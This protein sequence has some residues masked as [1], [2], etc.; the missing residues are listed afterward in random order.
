MSPE[1]GLPDVVVEIDLAGL[2]DAGY[3]I[4][5]V[6]RVSNVVEGA[7]GRV[8]SMAGG[9]YELYFPYPIAPE[10]IKVVTG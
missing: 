9:G 2:R 8:Y 1:R 7:S 3:E 10:F 4:P 6:S 5:T